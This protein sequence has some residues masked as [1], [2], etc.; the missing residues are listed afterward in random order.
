[1]GFRPSRERL[2]LAVVSVAW[3]LASCG[4]NKPKVGAKEPSSQAPIVFSIA[5]E[6]EF[7]GRK[8]AKSLPHSDIEALLDLPVRNGS[9]A[10]GDE[11]YGVEMTREGGERFKVLSCR[12]WKK[13]RAQKAYAATTFDMAMEGFLISTCGLLFEM[14]TAKSAHKNYLQDFRV[15]RAH[16]D[17]IPAKVLG[18]I[19]ELEANEEGYQYKTIA[20]AVPEGVIKV[21]PQG[22]IS[23]LFGGF[24]QRLWEGGRADFN[25]DGFED[26][27]VFL[28]GRADGGTM[29]FTEY[30]I[31]TRLKPVGS[32]RVLPTKTF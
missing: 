27:L 32:L 17:V 25:G 14:Q 30:C 26:V 5:Q 8:L 6:L 11:S 15:D 12:Q 2:C 10:S 1:M 21:P 3:V 4:G 20:Q 18:S 16:L 9:Q 29:G 7:K 28:G 13:A 19:G 22:G 23:L 24:H 31:L